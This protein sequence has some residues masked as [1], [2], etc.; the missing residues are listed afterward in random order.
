M[1]VAEA[2]D[3]G[4]LDELLRVVD[5]LCVARDWDSLARLRALCTR[6]HERGRQLWPAAAQ[7]EY[8]LALEAP[9]PFAA[10]VLVEGAGRFTLGPLPEVAA[11][12]H[13]W[14]DLAPHMA[15]G[16]EAVVTMHERVVRGEDCREGALPGPPVLDLPRTLTSW[17]P[18]YPV[19]EYGSHDAQFPS[20]ELPTRR[21]TTLPERGGAERDAATEA[22]TELA[23]TWT[24]ASDGRAEAVAVSGGPLD[25]VAALGPPVAR[26]AP[27]DGSAAMTLMAWAASSGGA[28]GRRPGAAAGRF[29]AWWALTAL[30]G[31]LERWPDVDDELGAALAGF[32]WLVWDAAEPSTGWELR[33]AVGDPRRHRAW[34]VAAVDARS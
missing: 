19:A 20:P 25:A 22:L 24:I 17:E 11:S 6:A 12:T 10:A 16:P 21:E 26:V 8:R 15:P 34:A 3:R 14:T 2:V 33:L 7:A 18:T 4:D 27:I 31:A 28:H 9:A 23:R 29:A 30:A 5:G 1:D 13:S 32:E